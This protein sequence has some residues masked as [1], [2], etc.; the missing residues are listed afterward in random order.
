MPDGSYKDGKSF[1]TTPMDIARGIGVG[2]AKRSI[3]AEVKIGDNEAI[4]WDLTRPLE[5]DCELKILTFNDPKG[6]ETFWHSSSHV[7]GQSM[8]RFVGIIS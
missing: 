6:K 7:L 3:V 8:E 1:E 4:F 2:L 5:C